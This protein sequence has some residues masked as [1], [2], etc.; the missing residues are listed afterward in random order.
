MTAL[1]ACGHSD[2]LKVK[3][4]NAFLHIQSFSLEK[5]NQQP[6]PPKSKPKKH[7]TDRTPSFSLPLIHASKT[8]PL[9]PTL[10]VLDY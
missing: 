1:D 8:H 9:L 5:Q 2:H 7:Q 4:N 3:T 6:P 10:A